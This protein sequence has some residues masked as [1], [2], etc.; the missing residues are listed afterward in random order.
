[1]EVSSVGGIAGCS[2]GTLKGCSNSASVTGNNAFNLET[3][4][5]VSLGSGG[6]VGCNYSRV[7]SCSNSGSVTGNGLFTG[8]V[9]GYNTTNGTDI[10]TIDNSYNTGA[11]SGGSYVGGVAG[12]NC[13]TVAQCFNTGNVTG[14]GNYTGGVVGRNAYYINKIISMN[15]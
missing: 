14:P 13:V 3:K 15:I 7:E 5:E 9:V 12:Y 1:M 2:D 6:V 10:G 8:G 11:V 4:E